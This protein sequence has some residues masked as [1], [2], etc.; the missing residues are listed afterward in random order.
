MPA[1]EAEP[2]DGLNPGLSRQG[3]RPQSRMAGELQ[4]M[5]RKADPLARPFFI[6]LTDVILFKIVIFF[7]II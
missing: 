4:S 3:Y 7:A 5:Q 1:K 6:K 2:P